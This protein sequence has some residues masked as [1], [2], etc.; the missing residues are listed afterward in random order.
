MQ[1]TC[2]GCTLCCK[3]L[4]IPELKKPLNTICSHCTVGVGCKIYQSRPGSCRKFYCRYITDNLSKALKPDHCHVVFEK[5]PN[6]VVYLALIDPDYPNALDNQAVKT[7]IL[8]LLHDNF[9]IITSSGPNSVKNLMLAEGVTQEEAWAKVN[10]A[11][12][13]M[14]I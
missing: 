13:L 10:Q 4:A 1:N 9:S 12:K 14:N 6:C 3:L 5:L 8:Q 2:D 11:Y 7:Q